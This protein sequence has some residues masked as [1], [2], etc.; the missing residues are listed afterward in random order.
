MQY[1]L[2]FRAF[3][4]GNFHMK[5]CDIFLIFAQNTDLGYLQSMF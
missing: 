4:F 1:A 5:K 2:I 3:N